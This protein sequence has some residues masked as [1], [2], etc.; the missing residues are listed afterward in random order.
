MK[1]LTM[2]E[3]FTQSFTVYKNKSFVLFLCIFVFGQC[4]AD[5]V[6]GLAVYY[7][8]DVLNAY[9]GGNFTILMGVIL[10]AQFLGMILFGP[11]MAKTT[12]KFPILVAT[13]IRAVATLA[14]LLFSYEGANF[15]IILALSFVIGLGMAATST[16]IYAILSDM[17]DVDQL[18]TS[19]N[20]SGTVSG[21]A[22]F[23][24]KISTGLS[25]FVIGLLLA[26]VHYDEVL[27]AAGERQAASVQSGIAYIYVFAQI[28]LLAI[29]YVVTIAFPLSKKEF[30]VIVKEIARR[31]GEDHS[32]TTEEEK[33]ICE[34][35]TGFDYDR[36]WD[37]NNALKFHNK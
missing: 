36:L 24:R 34:K 1:H 16:S 15:T 19:M 31:K 27:A 3:T 6:T 13:P 18:I 7:V 28:V 10:L 22:T 14:M 33:R 25:S 20:R 29:T 12:K 30:H 8:D 2:G 35:V 4:A 17:A 26:A 21:M 11:I 23:I 37:K 9:G 5:F 32:E